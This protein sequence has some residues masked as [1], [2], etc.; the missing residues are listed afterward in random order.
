MIINKRNDY[1]K[2]D[3][4]KNRFI[5]HEKITIRARGK[6][7]CNMVMEFSGMLESKPSHDN[8]SWKRK[9]S[10]KRN[11]NIEQAIQGSHMVSGTRC[12]AQLT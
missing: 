6:Q 11:K 3:K 10:I 8:R 1:E 9:E 2:K 4:L 7:N 12:P 5:N